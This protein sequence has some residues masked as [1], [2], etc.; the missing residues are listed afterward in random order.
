M[1]SYRQKLG[2]PGFSTELPVFTE[3]Q[4]FA[5]LMQPTPDEIITNLFLGNRSCADGYLDQLLQE[6]KGDE[7]EKSNGF[8]ILRCTTHPLSEQ[9]VAQKESLEQKQLFKILPIGDL[10]QEN[11]SQHFDDCFNFIEAALRK[12]K[13]VLVHCDAGAS[14]SPTIIAAYLI[15]KYGLTAVEAFNHIKTKR[16]CI[17]TDNFTRQLEEYANNPSRNL[18]REF[19]EKHQSSYQSGCAHG[20]FSVTNLAMYTKDEKGFDKGLDVDSII[21]HAL[22]PTFFRN[23]NRTRKILEEM[24]VMDENGNITNLEFKALK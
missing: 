22:Q 20:F 18:M 17:N 10:A 5:S 11:I 1:Q 12:G 24:K 7:E 4:A 16:L 14:R 2:Q 8:V 3:E 9:A 13:K 15:R 23:K 19:L 6:E 21:T